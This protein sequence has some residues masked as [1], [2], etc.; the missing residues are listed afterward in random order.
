MQII[1]N[2]NIQFIKHMLRNGIE[3]SPL[4]AD[5]F[6]RNWIGPARKNLLIPNDEANKLKRKVIRGRAALKLSNLDMVLPIS[7]FGK[8]VSVAKSIAKEMLT[9]NDIM[10]RMKF[11][12][13]GGSIT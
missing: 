2:P 4:N 6:G 7:S 3:S 9:C 1:L 10:I 11:N 13:I 12:P 8:K 5:S